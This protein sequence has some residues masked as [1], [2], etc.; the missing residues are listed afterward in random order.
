LVFVAAHIKGF[1][2]R[3]I[4]GDNDRFFEMFFHEPAF[5][6]TLHIDA[7]FDIVLKFFLFVSWGLEQ[8]IDGFGI[9]DAFEF[10][11]E[12]ELQFFDEAQFAPFRLRLL[13]F[14]FR[15]PLGQEVKV[16]AVVLHNVPDGVANEGF[17]EVHIVLKVVEGHFR[18]HH[19]EFGEMAGGI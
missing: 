6:F 7:P 17:G 3:R 4:T 12:D 2:G 5:V 18:F 11:I 9:G 15:K 16:F 13:F 10:V 14:L 1:D 8:D 19:P